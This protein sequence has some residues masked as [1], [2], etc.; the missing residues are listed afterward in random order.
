MLQ[1]ISCQ[2]EING[3]V[4]VLSN[5]K[6]NLCLD[7]KNPDIYIEYETGCEIYPI[8]NT[9]NHGLFAVYEF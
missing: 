5:G 6:E 8:T 3:L 1:E 7:Y 2:M 9:V 4:R